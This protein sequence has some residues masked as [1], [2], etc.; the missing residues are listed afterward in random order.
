VAQVRREHAGQTDGAQTV[1]TV[2][3]WQANLW[4]DGGAR[5]GDGVQARGVMV[6][7]RVTWHGQGTKGR[8]KREGPEDDSR[9]CTSKWQ[10]LLRVSASV[11]QSEANALKLRACRLMQTCSQ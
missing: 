8:G 6:Q 9:E 1:Q 2:C 11:S 3:R 7:G 5:A 4:A 10:F